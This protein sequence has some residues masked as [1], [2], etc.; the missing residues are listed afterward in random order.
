[1]VRV[2]LFYNSNHKKLEDAM[3]EF[4]A[5]HPD[6]VDIKMTESEDYWSALIIYRVK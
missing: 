5:V 2:K 4:L 3:N 1:M 6:I